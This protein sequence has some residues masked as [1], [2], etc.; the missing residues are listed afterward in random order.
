MPIS[1]TNRTTSRRSF[2][3]MTAKELA[4]ELSVPEFLLGRWRVG[5]KPNFWN[6]V[7]FSDGTVSQTG[8]DPTL[9]FVIFDS[10]K[11]AADEHY[12]TVT[13]DSGT[14]DE[15]K[16]HLRVRNQQVRVGGAGK[17]TI[18]PAT[19]IEAPNVNGAGLFHRSGGSGDPSEV[20]YA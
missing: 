8:D 11:W 10:G 14:T 3:F 7:F 12:V 4:A 17:S 6:N 18:Q 20:A 13:W 9:K 5:T 16:L 1:S 2:P 15:W 19:R